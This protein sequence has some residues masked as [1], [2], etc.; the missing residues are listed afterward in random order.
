MKILAI[1]GKNLASLYGEFELRLD[2][3]PI[4]SCNLFAIFGPTGSGKSTLLDALCLA[5]YGKTPRL[6]DEGGHPVGAPGDDEK[7]RLKSNDAR[8]LLSRGT[9]DGFA[10][11]DFQGADGK[12]LRA[13]WRVRR[14]RGKL[15][16]YQTQTM[17]LVDIDSGDTV[18]SQITEVRQAVVAHVGF[19]FDEFKRTVLLPQFEFTNFLRAKPDDRAQIL[20][21]VMGGDT[22]TKLSMAAHERAAN[23][24]DKLSRLRDKLGILTLLSDDDR[25]QLDSR[26][27]TTAK[28]LADAQAA[29]QSASQDLAWHE[30]QA[31]LATAVDK[32][33]TVL[34]DA[35]D[36]VTRA[37]PQ[38]KE[39]QA[40]SAAQPLRTLRDAAARAATAL[41]KAEATASEARRRVDQAGRDAGIAQGAF[42][43]AESELGLAHEREA[44]L[45]PKIDV[46]KGLDIKIV[47][48]R[49]AAAKAAL[50]LEEA[51]GQIDQDRVA[52]GELDQEIACHD[53]QRSAGT[54][55]LAGHAVEGLL[56]AEWPRWRAELGKHAAICKRLS[57]I[58]GELATAE[59]SAAIAGTDGAQAAATASEVELLFKKAQKF[60]EDAETAFAGRDLAAL[61]TRTA[62]LRGT[63]DALI[64]LA[65]IADC[66]RTALEARSRAQSQADEFRAAEEKNR[67]EAERLAGEIIGCDSRTDEARQAVD[68]VRTALSFDE[69]RNTLSDGKPC[70]LCGATEHPYAHTKVEPSMLAPLEAR[71]RELSRRGRE[72]Q[73]LSNTAA[74]AQAEARTSA[75]VAEETAMNRTAEAEQAQDDYQAQAAS[76]ALE[77]PASAAQATP[78]IAI[79]I[80]KVQAAFEQ[81][82]C[83]ERRAL[84][85]AA[86]RDRARER[87]DSARTAWNLAVEKHAA[88][89]K[90]EQE[91][92]TQVSRLTEE[93]ARLVSE[94]DTIEDSLS[95]CMAWRPDWVATARQTPEAFISN[96]QVCVQ[97][98]GEWERGVTTATEQLGVLRGRQETAR[99]LLAERQHRLDS[100]GLGLQSLQETAIQLEAQRG[101]LLEGRTTADVETQLATFLAEAMDA[102]ETTR[103]A[104]EKAAT[105]LALAQ[106][107]EETAVNAVAELS[108]EARENEHALDA[109]IGELG[110]DRQSLERCLVHDEEW[111]SEQRKGLHALREVAACARTAQAV[112]QR[113]MDEHAAKGRPEGDAAS[114]MSQV[115]DARQQEA[116]LGRSLIELKARQQHDDGQRASRASAEAEASAQEAASKI[117]EQLDDVIGSADGKKFRI[118]AQG[119]AFD[120]LVRQANA[121]LAD[122][123]P[124]Y[125]LMSVPGAALELQVADQDLGSE[126]RTINSLSGGEVF[127]VSLALALG[128]S[129]LS[130]RATQAQTL[131]IDEGFGTLDRDTLDHAMVALENLQATGRTVGIISHVPELQERFGAQVRVEKAGCGKSRVI[132]VSA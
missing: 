88:L 59:A 3:P 79:A 91:L 123:S 97:E 13:T 6:S 1:R 5:L 89:N 65:T 81:A 98:F 21:H 18:S 84:E 117:W 25:A 43:T 103:S 72:L 110:I 44:A 33:S 77:L 90:Q 85:L 122:L 109:A 8:A 128:L 23:E 67:L 10:E 35:E 105:E 92:A 4:S 61:N 82:E 26:A 19:T 115:A 119:L 24:R 125:R 31:E 131:F 32:A 93:H 40:V 108:K 29:L 12:R 2:Q 60:W 41:G 104:Y 49:E 111:I 66:A 76:P 22:F 17:A 86:E 73:D 51:H 9:V 120:A 64:T 114:G 46:A 121:H 58:A 129:S 74:T 38:E 11:A 48:A 63:R 70:P 99:A 47:Q 50:E 116:S 42:A 78:A 15:A 96:C 54:Q 14:A 130:T 83:E 94:R 87:L 101:A 69:Q 53:A 126:V 95:P 39:V 113:T 132:V 20:E 62:S 16:K 68:V 112:R 45:R 55:W 106:A 127:L 124:R 56:A 7:S 36:L 107:A 28:S 57:N 102:F 71:V 100:A 37:E 80:E 118:F 30:R 34:K 27:T 75:G 52:L